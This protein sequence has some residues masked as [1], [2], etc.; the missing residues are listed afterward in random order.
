M[1]KIPGKD[2]QETIVGVLCRSDLK[3]TLAAK[4]QEKRK[5]LS[6]ATCCQKVESI[7]F[8]VVNQVGALVSVFFCD[9]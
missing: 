3:E 8:Q 9:L 1:G 2:E 7:A 4:I 5:E 6:E